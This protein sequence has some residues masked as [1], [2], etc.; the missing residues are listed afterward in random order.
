M[1]RSYATLIQHATFVFLISFPDAD[2]S[3][4]FEQH[5]FSSSVIYQISK[6]VHSLLPANHYLHFERSYETVQFE[7]SRLLSFSRNLPFFLRCIFWTEAFST[8]FFFLYSLFSLSHN[9]HYT[10]EHIVAW[11]VAWLVRTHSKQLR[12]PLFSFSILYPSCFSYALMYCLSR[13][14]Y[15]PIVATTTPCMYVHCSLACLFAETFV[16][17]PGLCVDIF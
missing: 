12:P 3:L 6:S 17:W 16:F 14:Y 10:C 13:L 11:A 2:N 1:V 5:D 15:L 8:L 9:K 4:S 7:T